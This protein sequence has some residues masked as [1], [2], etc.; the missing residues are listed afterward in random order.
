MKRIILS[1][2][3]SL[4]LASILSHTTS[5]QTDETAI[6]QITTLL[7]SSGTSVRGASYNG[8]RIVFESQVDYTG[9]NADLNNE[10]F[11]FDVPTSKFLQITNTKNITDPA[12]ATKVLLNV[13]N[14]TPIISGDGRSIVFTSN[15]K[16]TDSTNDDG[17]QEIFLASLPLNA[18]VATFLRITNTGK[19]NADEVVKEIFNNYSPTVNADGSLVAFLS[20]RRVFQ[21]LENGTIEFTAS[22]EGPNRDQVPDANAELFLY[23]VTNKTYTQVTISRDV[24]ATVNFEVRGFN[25]VPHLSGNGQ[26]LAFISGFNYPGTNSGT[27]LDFNGEVFIYRRGDATNTFRQLTTT[28]GSSAVPNTGVMNLLPA[29]TRPLNAAGTLLVFES[30]GDFAAKNTDKTREI[31]LADLSGTQPAFRQITDQATAEIG[32]SDF[33][34]LP[35][36]NDAGTFITFGSVLNLVPTTPSDSKTDNGDS[37]RDLFRYDV[38][39]STVAAPKFRQLTFTPPAE[40][41]L[42]P[43]LATSFSFPDSTGNVVTFDYVAFLIAPNLSFVTEIFQGLILPIATKNAQAATLANAASFDT[44]QL[45][46]ESIGAIFGTQLANTTAIASTSDLPYELAGV[47]VTF[48]NISARLLFVSPGQINL[49]IPQGIAEGDAIELSVNNNGVQS[50][51]K[52]KIASVGPGVFTKTSTGVGEAAALCGK[53]VDVVVDGSTTQVFVFSEQPCDVGTAERGNFLVVFGTGWRLGGAS[54]TVTIGGETLT[55]TFSGAQPTF[56]GLDQINL[57]LTQTLKGKGTV[58]VTV[59]TGTIVSKTV[60][61]RIP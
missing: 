50:T 53:I 43:R 39:N 20:T 59:N 45:A 47:R 26:V 57:A 12:D 29:F 14:S 24:D 51:G 27:N 4:F 38:I 60:T 18:T 49:V 16:L 41:L 35:S 30:A 34:L 42:D 19:L 48:R 2:C 44:A 8:S 36:I 9:Q 3:V 1:F 40:F 46:R 52:A 25:G 33:N 23:S 54:T 21:A 28:L 15:A 11:V 17:N 13:S 58:D 22:Q 37:S 56:F 10:I 7:N 32:K 5:A 6:R 55:P 61:V 31:Y